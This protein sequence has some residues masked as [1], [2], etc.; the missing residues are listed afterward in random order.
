VVT[1]V[2]FITEYSG[3]CERGWSLVWVECEV[4]RSVPHV[5]GNLSYSG[6]GENI[7]HLTR[8]TCR[9]ARC[10]SYV[11]VYITICSAVTV[12]IQDV[13]GVKVNTSGFNST[14]DTESKTP[15]THT[16]GSDSQRFRSYE[17]L[18]YTK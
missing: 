12:H 8:T 11:S 6:G 1:A 15:Y 5:E 17:F 7:H 3:P 9:L 18:K 14:A 4:Q 16:Q 2:K 10:A 13:P